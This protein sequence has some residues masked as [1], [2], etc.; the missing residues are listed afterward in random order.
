MHSR[1]LESVVAVLCALLVAVDLTYATQAIFAGDDGRYLA[2]L[3]Y[4]VRDG[5]FAPF[6]TLTSGQTGT[7]M[8][9]G[10]SALLLLAPLSFGAP[11]V[12]TALTASA[13]ASGLSL[14]LVF[15]L[16]RQLHSRAAGLLAVFVY[17][18]LQPTDLRTREL[19]FFVPLS[20][21]ALSLGIRLMR[22]RSDRGY[23]G[24][25]LA[26]GLLT[27]THYQGL[28]LALAIASALSVAFEAAP[29]PRPATLLATLGVAIVL[30]STA[31]M[32]LAR[33]PYWAVYAMLLSAL[34][35]PRLPRCARAAPCAVAA[36]VVG[37]VAVAPAALLATGAGLLRPVWA[38]GLA[39]LCLALGVASAV[40]MLVTWVRAGRPR[41]GSAPSIV[42]PWL[43]VVLV[44]GGAVLTVALSTPWRPYF[45]HPVHAVLSLAAGVVLAQLAQRLSARPAARRALLALALC[46]G[47]GPGA[48]AVSRRVVRPNA[49]GEMTLRDA[50]RVVEALAQRDG[51]PEVRDHVSRY[52]R[53]AP[54]LSLLFGL[55][56]G[57]ATPDRRLVAYLEQANSQYAR[58]L[59]ARAPRDRQ[60][61]GRYSLFWFDRD[62]DPDLGR[63]PRIPLASPRHIG[64]RP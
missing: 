19:M 58:E 33:V 29:T 8:L 20:L 60:D 13:L 26:L 31:V 41:D 15:V 50:R 54:Q 24:V 51:E 61:I 53:H 35:W 64:A 21:L 7:M 18:P 49:D 38:G 34:L 46:A 45:F 12:E 42:I 17:L 63:A 27:N 10:G 2:W 62:R 37:A 40:S 3:Q 32:A 22:S 6:A 30:A 44:V 55:T 16:G 43:G 5:H 59:A 48:A 52:H 4:C 47:V 28:L 14:W 23:V 39:G 36:L 9:G 57:V 56:P 25:A 1:R 11:L